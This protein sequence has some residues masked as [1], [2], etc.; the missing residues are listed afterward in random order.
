MKQEI[1]FVLGVSTT[2][3]G[4]LICHKDSQDLHSHTAKD[5]I[6]VKGSHSRDKKGKT[7]MGRSPLPEESQRMCLTPPIM[8]WDSTG[9]MLSTREA[10][11]SVP[12]VFTW[13]WSSRHPL[14]GM[15]QNSRLP[16]IKQ[17]FG[18]SHIVSTVYVQ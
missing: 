6:A 11:D 7:C 8:G 15:S 9:E 17:V 18:I 4:L 3:S 1:V 2:P 12:K 16:Q 5:H 14:P 13:G 10:L